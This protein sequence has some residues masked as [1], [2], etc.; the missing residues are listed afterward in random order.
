[1]L[2]PARLL[3][4]DG[5]DYREVADIG[6]VSPTHIRVLNFH[7]QLG[8]RQRG[9]TV[10]DEKIPLHLLAGWQ[11]RAGAAHGEFF[12][13]AL[14]EGVHL[15]ERIARGVNLGLL[16]GGGSGCLAGGLVVQ[17]GACVRLEILRQT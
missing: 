5:L 6:S 14:V 8:V 7:P 16:A 1:M 17:L 3:G 13:G 2:N 15:V 9:S 11:R 12:V 10:K 4:S